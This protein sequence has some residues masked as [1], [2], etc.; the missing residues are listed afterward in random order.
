MIQ[1]LKRIFPSLIIYEAH[2]QYPSDAYKWF[3]TN[4]KDIIGIE[5]KE[6]TAKENNI[7]HTFLQPYS[8][9]F[10][11]PTSEEVKWLKIINNERRELQAP[12]KSFRFVYFIFKHNQISPQK[13]K[14]SMEALFSCSIPIL[15]E[16][17]NEGILIEEISTST[18]EWVSYEQ[19]IDVLM[20]DLY[21]KISF[22]VGPYMT[23][24]ANAST[25]YKTLIDSARTAF[26]GTGKQVI[27]FAEAVP[28]LLIERMEEPFQEELI[29]LILK[30]CRTDMDLLREILT[31]FQCNLNVSVAAKELHMHRNSLQYRL[32]K[33]FDKTGID[34]REFHQ[35]FTV[36]LTI[37][38]NMH[39]ER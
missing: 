8:I 23:S 34:L 39:R 16:N 35:A 36:Y 20:S 9:Q 26:M 3:I 25:H 19:I 37:L 6:L 22:L 14:E 15:W 11:A 2:K 33:F 21:V 17:E 1:Q 30:E 27:S 24:I 38:V 13:F 18:D 5:K 31:F 32:D 28:S 29:S 10:P 4:N 7:L 12:S